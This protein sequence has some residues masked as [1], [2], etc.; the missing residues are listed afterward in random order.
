MIYQFNCSSC[1]EA[2]ELNL[3]IQ[4]R[5]QPKTEPCPYCGERTVEREISSLHISQYGVKSVQ[6]RAGRDFNDILGRI[7]KNHAPQLADG[8]KQTINYK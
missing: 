5:D 1:N 6:T 2:F 3:S 7:S 8:T 4:N